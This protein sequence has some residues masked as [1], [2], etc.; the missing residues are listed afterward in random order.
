VALASLAELNAAARALHGRESPEAQASILLREVEQALW[1]GAL[2]FDLRCAPLRT[3][4]M[5]RVV[6][7]PAAVP[8]SE[9]GT[10]AYVRPDD[11]LD[12][13]VLRLR[14]GVL[15]FEPST[16]ENSSWADSYQVRGEHF[17]ICDDGKYGDDNPRPP[18]SLEYYARPPSLADGGGGNFV[19]RDHDSVYINGFSAL[20]LSSVRL[21]DEAAQHWGRFCGGVASLN[22]TLGQAN[23]AGEEDTVLG[24]DGRGWCL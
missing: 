5:I 8:P 17:L 13:R 14:G 7:V 22:D 18:L 15:R 1:H 20:L 4:R 3:E 10:L 19:S 21:Q 23:A 6:E 12:G 11:Y 16:R 9:Q 2:N 24:G